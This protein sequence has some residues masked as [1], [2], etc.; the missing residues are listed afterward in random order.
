[1]LM[2]RMEASRLEAKAREQDVGRLEIEEIFGD[3]NHITDMVGLNPSPE[4][5]ELDEKVFKENEASVEQRAPVDPPILSHESQRLENHQ[6]SKFLQ[7]TGQSLSEDLGSPGRNIGLIEVHD[8]EE[9]QVDPSACERQYTKAGEESAIIYREEEEED[10]KELLEEGGSN[11]GR[12]PSVDSQEDREGDESRGKDKRPVSDC[13]VCGD[14]AIAHMHYGGICCYSCK[15]FFRRAVQSGKDKV[16]RC[17]R[18]GDCQVSVASRRSCQKCRFLKCIAVGMTAAW[19]LSEEQCTIRFGKNP[20]KCG[21]KRRASQTSHSAEQEEEQH[22]QM[23]QQHQEKRYLLSEEDRQ[24]V[25]HIG[26]LY[27]ASKEMISFSENNHALW[28]KIFGKEEKHAYSAGEI[29]SLVST[30]IKKNIFFIESN[31][32]F[33]QLPPG[34][35]HALLAKNMTEMCH[36]R[37]ALRFDP[38]KGS[39]QWYF[40]Q[41]DQKDAVQKQGKSI[42]EGDISNFYSSSEAA[43]NI[44]TNIERIVKTE[45]PPEVI[46]I[47]MHVV[48]FSGDGVKLAKPELASAA[49]V[50]YLSLIQRYLHSQLPSEDA[51]RNISNV[52]AL[53]VDLRETGEKSASAKINSRSLRTQSAAS[54]EQSLVSA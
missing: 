51:S 24:Q 34:D 4:K 28:E 3:I 31:F 8:Q 7:E 17:K 19:V 13:R 23:P 54:E 43:K 35:Q 10:K 40:N 39:F 26:G 25:A 52:M 49:Q 27:E 5:Q 47:M 9:A 20:G 42:T 16:Y 12:Q 38:S 32:F 29:S 45:L 14:R 15:A 53:L 18:S 50:H 37:G 1:M 30:L 11:F 21:R 36:L 6:Q 48:V 2:A 46:L 44:V 22:R 33:K 41:K